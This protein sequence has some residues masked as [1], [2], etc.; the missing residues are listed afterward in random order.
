MEQDMFKFKH[1]LKK[2]EY[3]SLKRWIFNILQIK[4]F[5]LFLI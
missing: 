3:S 5:L 2:I 4:F 1:L